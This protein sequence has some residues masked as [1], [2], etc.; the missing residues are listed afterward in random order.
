MTAIFG[1]D[2]GGVFRTILTDIAG[3]FI[4]NGPTP[5]GSDDTTTNPIL[6]GG[7]QSGSDSVYTLAVDSSGAIK[8]APVGSTAS[9]GSGSTNATPS[10]SA[11]VFGSTPTNGFE[12]MNI[13]SAD[14]W[15]NDNGAAAIDTAGSLKIPAGAQYTTPVGY[16]PIGDLRTI[17]ASASVKYTARRW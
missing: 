3:R 13:G 2:L 4:P 15:I 11:T 7:K 17:S 6:I 8:A 16:K 1:R 10:T 14:I 9:D 5:T 12:F